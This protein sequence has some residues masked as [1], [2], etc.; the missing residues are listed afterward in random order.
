MG[1]KEKEKNP[2]K[3]EMNKKELKYIK[4]KQKTNFSLLQKTKNDRNC[5]SINSDIF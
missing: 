2:A 1:E 3:D 4:K 5:G